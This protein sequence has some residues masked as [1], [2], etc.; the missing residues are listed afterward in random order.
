MNIMEIEVVYENGV[1]RPL[2]KVDLEEGVRIK[3]VGY[4]SSERESLS[5]LAR[6]FAGIGGYKGSIDSEKLHRIEEELYG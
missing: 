3:I 4:T 2:Q 5:E 1:F 6:K